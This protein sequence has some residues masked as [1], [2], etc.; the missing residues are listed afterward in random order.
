MNELERGHGSSAAVAPAPADW[1]SVP[2]G[3]REHERVSEEEASALVLAYQR[4][5][6]D[7]LARLHE[8]VGAIIGSFVYRY[9]PTSL[10]A[11]VTLQDLSQ[12]SWIILAEL[13]SR[14]RP[15]GSFLAYFFRSFPR[16]LYR[17][18]LRASASRRSGNVQM[19][20]LPYDDLVGELDRLQAAQ[21][22]DEQGTS[23]DEALVRL[24]PRE[25][26]VFLLRVEEGQDFEAVGHS[27]GISR[28]SA[29][30]LYRRAVAQLAE[31]G[32]DV[33]ERAE[34]RP[35]GRSDMAKLVDALHA[36]AGPEGVLPG[37]RKVWSRAGL[38]RRRYDELMGQLE[39]N[40]AIVD[41]APL[42]AGRLADRSA[43]ATLARVSAEECALQ[44]AEHVSLPA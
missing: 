15:S 42:R 29:Y 33:G 4:G 24:P 9:S 35:D 6:P 38:T 31:S 30:R 39:A 36:L 43:A 10:P 37:R 17:Y 2:G 26:A 44:H 23:W 7:S 34:A 41:R 28:S 40:G 1:P 18:V 12:Q 27:L 32:V 13:A 14:W 19:I 16:E 22:P 25:R 21:A 11:P 8:R 5:E 20:S 3:Q